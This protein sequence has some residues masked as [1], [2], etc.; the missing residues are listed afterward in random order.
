M[1]KTQPATD[2]RIYETPLARAFHRFASRPLTGPDF[3]N[4]CV[5]GLIAEP[6]ARITETVNTADRF[7]KILVIG[8]GGCGKS[9]ILNRLADDPALNSKHHIVSFSLTDAVNLMDAEALDILFAIYMQLLQT[10]DEKS[11]SQAM[12]DFRQLIQPLTEKFRLG[13]DAPDL[14]REI[15][16]RIRTE[17][18]FRLFLRETLRLRM[19]RLQTSIDTL[20]ERFSRHTYEC[21]RI[22][23]FSMDELREMAVSD[24]VLFRLEEIRDREYADRSDFLRALERRIGA[25]YFR[26]YGELIAGYAQQEEPMDVL[27][28]ADDMDKLRRTLLRRVVFEDAHLL[29]MPAAKIIW[30]FPQSAYYSPSFFQIQDRF[31]CEFVRPVAI[32]DMAGNIQADRQDMLRDMIRRRLDDPLADEAALQHMIRASGGILRDLN[33]MIQIA[34]RMSLSAGKDR[35][36]TDTAAAAIR[37]MVDTFNRFRDVTEHRAHLARIAGTR[38]VS[39][40]PRKSLMY[41]MRYH[42]VLEY[43][44]AGTPPWYDVHPWAKEMPE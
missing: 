32:Q 28:I 1:A 5:E 20:C 2:Y 15:F 31:V 16:F 24:A 4:L 36:D 8:P 11:R 25:E 43:G 35:I 44:R 27:I 18:P 17:T 6:A 30:T 7:G 22:N 23:E 42:F 33:R 21:W 14:I 40:I 37:T 13:A 34:C 10:V 39:G 29:I 12:S 9:S 38:T 41:L 26:R 3:E 19:D